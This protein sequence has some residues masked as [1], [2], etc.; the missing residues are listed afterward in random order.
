[1]TRRV[2]ELGFPFTYSIWKKF[3][4]VVQPFVAS[5]LNGETHPASP[6]AA[7]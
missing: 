7:G 3:E 2:K 5:Y 6:A 1:M 4:R